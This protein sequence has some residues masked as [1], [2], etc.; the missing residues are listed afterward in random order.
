MHHNNASQHNLKGDDHANIHPAPPRL[1]LLSERCV[2]IRQCYDINQPQ[3][4]EQQIAEGEQLTRQYCM[5]CHALPSP[6][7]HS[8]EQWLN[9][10]IRM[11]G[12]M[13]NRGLTVPDDKA[14]AAILT[15]LD[16][17]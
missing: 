12:Y 2:R 6:Q 11:E 17:E 5:Q 1:C 7:Q 8:P 3:S 15:Y 16:S 4:A 13:S 9:V 14:T 10:V